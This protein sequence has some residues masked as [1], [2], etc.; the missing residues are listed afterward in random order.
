MFGAF[1][2]GGIVM[3]K[4][5]EEAFVASTA[6]MSPGK[7]G[8][9]R[10]EQMQTI[11]ENEPMVS[12]D[13]QL[14]KKR[15]ELLATEV[16][17][18]I[19]VPENE[20]KEVYVQNVC[21]RCIDRMAD[22][23]ESPSEDMTFDEAQRRDLVRT[24][25]GDLK[26]EVNDV[27]TLDKTSIDPNCVPGILDNLP[28][29]I[30]EDLSKYC[31]RKDLLSKAMGASMYAVS[32]S[33][34]VILDYG[35]GDPE[36]LSHT[37][38]HTDESHGE[39]VMRNVPEDMEHCQ[40]TERPIDTKRKEKNTKVVNSIVKNKA[41]PAVRWSD[42]GDEVY[43]LEKKAPSA[44]EK[45]GWEQYEYGWPGEE[46]DSGVNS[47]SNTPDLAVGAGETVLNIDEN[48]AQPPNAPDTGV[49]NDGGESTNADG[50][51]NNAAPPLFSDDTKEWNILKKKNTCFGICRHREEC[52]VSKLN[53]TRFNQATL[54]DEKCSSLMMKRGHQ[55]AFS[56]DANVFNTYAFQMSDFNRLMSFKQTHGHLLDCDI[57][58]MSLHAAHLPTGIAPVIWEGCSKPVA[59]SILTV[60]TVISQSFRPQPQTD[61]IVQ[62]SDGH[63][64][65]ESW[66]LILPSSYTGVVATDPSR[67][68]R[69][70]MY[71][72]MAEMGLWDAVRQSPSKLISDLP[73][74]CKCCAVNPKKLKSL[75]C[76]AQRVCGGQPGL[77]WYRP[78]KNSALL[79]EA[80]S[81]AA[82]AIEDRNRVLKHLDLKRD[83]IIQDSFGPA[84]VVLDD[85]QRK[86]NWMEEM[87]NENALNDTKEE[88]KRCSE[89]ASTFAV[90][91][92]LYNQ[93]EKR[94]RD[95]CAKMCKY[96]SSF[97]GSV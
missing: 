13:T 20:E 61:A 56:V 95:N 76:V 41:V 45:C 67:N 46:E 63:S 7:L 39:M 37:V 23:V 5:Q 42:V 69:S 60:H 62:T 31:N 18:G 71:T 78:T 38:D 73:V 2:L 3:N 86:R 54:Y 74:E 47:R 34:G 51:G 33:V 59:A 48:A 1:L 16:T 79:Q 57:V 27:C 89:N 90:I 77:F 82:K 52:A 66:R 92:H 17:L 55:L 30:V 50:D 26:L 21:D 32:R 44:C 58:K 25:I 80:R 43:T 72:K 97:V 85:V 6:K 36:A 11:P 84:I 24:L 28:L 4:G 12:K 93:Q 8:R 75:G 19:H 81:D 9:R 14:S 87:G 35:K 49:P 70:V 94:E 91:T 68:W 15:L 53:R 96:V 40:C 83:E 29:P 88:L 64:V 10:A 65:Q 22:F